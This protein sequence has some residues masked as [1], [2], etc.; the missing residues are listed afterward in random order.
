[1]TKVLLITNKDDITTDFIVIKLKG[2]GVS[3]YRFNTEDIG[4]TV[5]FSF[6]FDKQQFLLIDNEQKLR[7]DLLLIKAVYYRRPEIY[8]D[9]SGLSA[10]EHNFIRSEYVYTLEGLYRILQ[11]AAWLNNV[12]NIR[13]AENKIYQLQL[14]RSLGMKTPKSLI[15]NRAED[16]LSFFSSQNQNC[17]IKPIKSGLVHHQGKEEGVIF[18]SKVHLDLSESQRINKSP[19]FLQNLIHK[20]G[21]VRVTVVAEDVFAAFIHSQDQEDSM[22]DWRKATSPL[23]YDEIELPK[24]LLGQC[25]DLTKKLGLNFAAIDLILDRNDRFIF[26]EINPNGQW[27]WIEK[28]LDFPISDT[29]TKFIIEKS[30][31]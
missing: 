24:M 15:T 7:I 30:S 18:T 11:G 2:W 14:A 28:H 10:G 26:L 27:A 9:G 16:A 12:F 31:S 23:A 6:D 13:E 20:K 5:S 1:M 29:I 19:V 8:V 25:L 21:D 4:Q 17:I 22:V 3:F